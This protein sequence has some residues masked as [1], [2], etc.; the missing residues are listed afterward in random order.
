MTPA[1]R[2]HLTE[3]D[4]AE[5]AHYA[6]H[7]VPLPGRVRPEIPVEAPASAAPRSRLAVSSAPVSPR[8]APEAVAIGAQPPGVDKAT[9]QRFR[10][11]KL[12]AARTLDLHGRT[13]QRAYHALE[14][15]L[16]SAHGDRLR[17]V[18]VITGRGTGEEGGVLRRELPL[19]LNLAQL[20][21]LVLAAAHP[22]PANP[23]SVRLLLRR[24]R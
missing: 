12:V 4:R 11:G 10:T 24:V 16:R 20:R 22:H 5:W 18:E 13:A 1:R 6:R 9:W 15:F 23:G 8:R 7:V 21:P 19:W 17:C 3:T 14:A 2:T